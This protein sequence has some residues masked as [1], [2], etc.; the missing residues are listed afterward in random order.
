MSG[1]YKKIELEFD[2]KTY[3]VKPDWDFLAYMEEQQGI[4]LLDAIS[5]VAQRKLKITECVKIITATL[6]YAGAN[7]EPQEVHQSFG[8]YNGQAIILAT[9]ILMACDFNPVSEEMAK[10]PAAQTKRKPVVKK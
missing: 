4:N 10:K 3:E 8:T 7:V 5:S 1:I 9:Q 6:N 2:G